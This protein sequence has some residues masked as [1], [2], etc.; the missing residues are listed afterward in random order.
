L[1]KESR[2]NEMSKICDITGD[3]EKKCTFLPTFVGK[4]TISEFFLPFSPS[5]IVTRK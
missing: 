5:N 2:C 3:F 4:M 1:A